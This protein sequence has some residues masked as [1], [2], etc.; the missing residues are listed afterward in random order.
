MG[1]FSDGLQAYSTGSFGFKALIDQRHRFPQQFQVE[2]I[3]HYSC[4]TS[5]GQDFFTFNKIFDFNSDPIGFQ[6]M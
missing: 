5:A 2:I 6:A 4:N 1:D 3:Q